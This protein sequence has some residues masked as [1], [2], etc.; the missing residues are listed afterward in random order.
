MVIRCFKKAGSAV[1]EIKGP[2]LTF[3]AVHG[4]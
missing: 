3:I 2:N 1:K 4:Y